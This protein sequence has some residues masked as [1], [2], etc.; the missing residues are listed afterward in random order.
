[1]MKKQELATNHN[2]QHTFHKIIQK[3]KKERKIEQLTR[4]GN[5]I[6]CF[7]KVLLLLLLFFYIVIII[8]FIL[9]NRRMCSS[10]KSHTYHRSK[11]KPLSWMRGEVPRGYKVN[12][13]PKLQL[14]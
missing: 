11:P 2:Y 14:Y 10:Y 3:R 8:C 1:M 9:I 12:G 7:P 4:D 6:S 13:L 5:L